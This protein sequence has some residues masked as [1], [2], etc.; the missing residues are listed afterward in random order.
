MVLVVG[1]K[2]DVEK[3]L[4]KHGDKLKTQ[5][6]KLAALSAI[7]EKEP[8]LATETWPV[9]G[10]KWPANIYQN[11]DG[12][13][14]W[15]WSNQLVDPCTN[16]TT[17]FAKDNSGSD[18]IIIT[19]S[20]LTTTGDLLQYPGCALTGKKELAEGLDERAVKY[21]VGVRY[22]LVLRPTVKD[23]PHLDSAEVSASTDEYLKTGKGK[24][25][26]HFVP[27]RIAGDALLY[28][29]A[30]SKLA[31]GFKFD[32]TSSE[33]VKVQGAGID[34]IQQDVVDHLESA[35]AAKLRM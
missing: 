18:Y 16:R 31:G 23:A 7:V 1:C 10:V 2:S 22:A 12:N 6:D 14:L 33:T 8:P 35:L 13:A 5:L 3:I 28:D 11:P 4:D 29:L 26:E 30:T 32:V 15:I 24:D 27:G 20:T 19:D 34:E 17:T 21:L 9:P 25:V